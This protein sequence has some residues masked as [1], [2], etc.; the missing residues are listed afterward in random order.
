MFIAWKHSSI[1]NASPDY[2]AAPDPVRITTMSPKGLPKTKRN[3]SPDCAAAPDPVR[4]TTMSPR[5][6]P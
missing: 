2:A 4:I 1:L 5:G 3:A 6:L